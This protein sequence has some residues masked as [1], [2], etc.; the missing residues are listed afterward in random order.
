MLS[1][2]L[3]GAAIRN[4][5][6]TR[7][8]RRIAT[9]TLV[10]SACAV[11]LAAWAAW[12]VYRWTRV[13]VSVTGLRA[14]AAMQPAASGALDVTIDLER[15]QYRD[16]TEV[17]FDGTDVT[18]TI[19]HTASGFRFVPA[20]P[21]AEGRHLLEVE[22]PRPIFAA[23]VF[24]YPFTVD[25]TPPQL[26]LP[27]HTEPAPL[28]DP[29]HL[30]GSSE[31][32]AE[33]TVDGRAVD[34]DGE[35][36]FSMRLAEPVYGPPLLVRVEDAAGNVTQQ[37]IA[38]PV[39]YPEVR[40]PHLRAEDWADPA[41]RARLLALADEGKIT[42]VELDVKDEAGNVG[43][44]TQLATP[45]QIGAAAD[46]YDLRE[47]VELLHEH[48]VHVTVRIVA[49]NDPKFGQWA[50]DRGATDLVIQTPDGA[51]L[52]RNEG[53]FLN[54]AHPEVRDYLRDLVLEVADAGV[55]DIMFDYIR[56]PDGAVTDMRIPGLTVSPADGIVD[57]LREMRATIRDSGHDVYLGAA[58][59]GLTGTEPRGSDE[60]GQDVRAMSSYLDYVAPMVYP[61][62]FGRGEYGL[63][64][65]NE[66]PALLIERALT[67]FK[68]L[69]AARGTA[70]VPWIQDFDFGGKEYGRAEVRAQID[71]ACK[72]GIYNHLLWNPSAHFTAEALGYCP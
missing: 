70:L 16:R 71:A 62:H 2:P 45:R 43:Y 63:A 59:F 9:A 8:R 41:M 39:A 5:V 28:G 44:T 3:A 35:G 36:R 7:S 21:L 48:D 34:V 17:R 46:L 66:E 40:G 53:I 47:A 64:V 56:R 52:R 30:N 54:F 57:F 31:P 65:P 25:G 27:A 33:V 60:I 15:G 1:S 32:G 69:T 10:V 51:M 67:D 20:E 6:A 11:A 24:R 14:G 61:S 55:D 18:D 19:E 38:T 58:V 13:E 68:A 72:L 23:S 42:A 4:P 22:V 37:K 50:W 26:S 49:F 29:V 12:G